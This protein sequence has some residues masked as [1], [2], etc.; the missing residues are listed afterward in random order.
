MQ[1]WDISR[2]HF[3]QPALREIHVDLSELKQDG[4]HCDLQVKSVYQEASALWQED[5][6]HECNAHEKN[7]ESR[8]ILAM[9]DGVDHVDAAL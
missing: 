1:F 2:A 8:A 6:T 7:G 5:C 4:E 9:M 3:Y